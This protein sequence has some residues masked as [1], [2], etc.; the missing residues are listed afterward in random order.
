M[1]SSAY[2]DIKFIKA[3]CYHSTSCPLEGADYNILT[4][5]PLEFFAGSGPGTTQTVDIEIIDDDNV[6]VT[7]TFSLSLS[8]STMSI[9]TQVFCPDI[10]TV[11]IEDTDSNGEGFFD[12]KSS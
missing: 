7:E 3:Q 4:Q 1:I 6:E 11:D 12:T 8:F 2:N 9:L 5:M 10:L